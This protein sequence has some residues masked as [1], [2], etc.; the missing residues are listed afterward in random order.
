MFRILETMARR[1]GQHHLLM[2]FTLPMSKPGLRICLDRGPLPESDFPHRLDERV[3][4]NTTNII[5]CSSVTF[6]RL[7]KMV[8]TYD[9]QWV[10]SLFQ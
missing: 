3:G 7:N 10:C 2:G 8:E 4:L 1:T 5:P 6:I 9:R